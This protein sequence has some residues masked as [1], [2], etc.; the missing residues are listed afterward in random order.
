MLKFVDQ[1]TQVRVMRVTADAAGKNSRENIG[2]IFKATLEKK[3]DEKRKPS[4]GELEEIDKVV[5]TLQR[6]KMLR[7]QAHA[8]NFPE[9]MREVME[10]YEDSANATERALITESVKQAL[11]KIRKI[12]RV[13]SA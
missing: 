2:T 12:E 9:I 4:K 6:S 10:Y 1:P 11:Q 8:L 3:T 13:P 5:E 7:T